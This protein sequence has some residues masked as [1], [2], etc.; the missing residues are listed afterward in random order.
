MNGMEIFLL[1]VVILVALLIMVINFYILVYFSHPE[2]NFTGGIWIYRILVIGV[3]TFACYLI[4]AI[5]LDITCAK[6]EDSMQ[7]PYDMDFLW[8]AINFACCVIIMFVL[9]MAIVLYNDDGETLKDS[10][11]YALKISVMVGVFHIVMVCIYFFVVKEAEV[12]V[13]HIVKTTMDFLPSDVEMKKADLMKAYDATSEASYINIK[14]GI[15]NA[16]TLHLTIIGSILLIFIEGYGLALLPM[17]F[18]NSYL[19]RPQIVSSDHSREMPKISSSPNSFCES[20]M[21]S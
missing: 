4:F 14:L 6:R 10:I 7:L 20:K 8:L 13:K 9:P 18:L 21:R 15:M 16:C 2:D 17:E 19:N 12:D 11:K 3:L 1:I 5:P